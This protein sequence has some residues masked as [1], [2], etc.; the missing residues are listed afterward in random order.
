MLCLFRRTMNYLLFYFM[1]SNGIN[2]CILPTARYNQH[3][4][5]GYCEI[6][7]VLWFPTASCPRRIKIRCLLIQKTCVTSLLN[8]RYRR[9][10]RQFGFCR[11]F[12]I[13]EYLLFQ[14]NITEVSSVH[15]LTIE[16]FHI[17]NFLAVQ[18][19]SSILRYAR[20]SNA[21]ISGTKS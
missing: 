7:W 8:G 17:D 2:F 1:V 16:N 21:S 9:V 20:I 18:G 10:T 6:L 3:V 15:L 11:T 14:N 13:T 12:R 5:F 19:T 4:Y